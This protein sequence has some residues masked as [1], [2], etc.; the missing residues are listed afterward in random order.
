MAGRPARPGVARVRTIIAIDPGTEQSGVVVWNNGKS[1]RTTT[2]PN[3]DTLKYLKDAIPDKGEQIELAVEM[4]ASFGMPA[5]RELFE[6][7]VWIGRFVEAWS[8]RGLK[9]RLIYRKD[10]K[11]HHCQNNAAKD[12]NIRQAILDR[13]GGKAKAIGLKK[14]PGPLYGVTGDEWQAVALAIYAEETAEK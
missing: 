13:F 9:Y 1:Y 14:T 6:T 7:C 4:I 5:G 10:V 2:L 11:M 8:N 3:A 12:A